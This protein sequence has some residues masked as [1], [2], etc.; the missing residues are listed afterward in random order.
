MK[1]NSILLYILLFQLHSAQAQKTLYIAINNQEC[2]NCLSQ[3]SNLKKIDNTL[4]KVL[5]FPKQNEFDSI[6]LIK[7][8]YLGSFKQN[9]IWSDSIYN[10]LKIRQNGFE[11]SVTLVNEENGKVIKTPLSHLYQ[12][13]KFIN[14]LAASNDTISFKDAVFSTENTFETSDS[15]IYCFNYIS[16]QMMAF[17]RVNSS[18]L[19][20]I[21][22]TDSLNKAAFLMRYGENGKNRWL[23]NS[24]LYEE[25]QI[26]DPNVYQNYFIAHDTIW[27]L[28]SH[29]DLI[30]IKE[31]NITITEPNH[32]LTLSTYKQGKLI[33]FSLVENYLGPE[34]KDIGNGLPTGQLGKEYDSSNFIIPGAF[35]VYSGIPYFYVINKDIFPKIQNYF[36][37][38]YKKKDKTTWIFKGFFKRNLPNIYLNRLGYGYTN[39]RNSVSCRPYFA[40]YGSD[41]LFSVDS[42]INDLKLNLLNKDEPLVL[43]QGIWDLKVSKNFVYMIVMDQRIHQYCYLK[44]DIQQLKEVEYIP[45]SDYKSPQ[46]MGTPKIDD[47][48]FDFV[49]IPI[50]HNQLLRTCLATSKD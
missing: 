27:L 21:S 20:T 50:T 11:S 5:V 4:K 9:I 15:Y 34:F 44:Y 45:F 33:A 13:L 49:L 8:L 40:L 24:K 12:N 6:A 1:M 22:L 19:Y 2:T 46:F 30:P 17:D 36:L 38:E 3:L 28:G 32:F 47:L 31:N 42:N 37:A 29:T 25:K 10:L 7:R 18:L 48:D 16:Y 39:I 43:S 35:L 26:I 23:E 41:H 14:S